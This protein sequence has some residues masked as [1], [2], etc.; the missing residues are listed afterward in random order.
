MS[1]AIPPSTLQKFTT[2]GDLLR[3][4][5]R[6]AGITQVELSLAVGY[7]NA[8]ISR[9]EQN[10]RPPDPTTI[11]A[12]FVPALGLENEPHATS[13]LLELA[14]TVRRE[15]S[16]SAG[17]CPYKGLTYFDEG[18]ADLFVG[19]EAVTSKLVGRVLRLTSRQE[20]GR[21]RFLT[22]VGASGS[23][24][25]SLVRAGLLPALRWNPAS[26]DWLIYVLTPTAHPIESLALAL[27]TEDG[28]VGAPARFADDLMSNARCLHL[29]CSRAAK[30][31]AAAHVLLLVDQFEELFSLCTLETERQAFVGNLL[32]AACDP[33]GA[34]IVLTTLRADFYTHCA[35]YAGLREALAQQQEYIGALN[36]VELRR[37]IEE[38]AR[39][40]RWDFEP[41]LVDLLV[42]DVGH[43]PGALPLLSH[44]LL[45]TWER[46]RGRTMTL[47]GYAASGG[48]RGAIAETAQAVFEDRFS[49]EQQAIARRIFLH[50]TE[51]GDE[52]GTGDT[53]R[54]ASLEEL[55][56]EPGEAHATRIVLDALVDAR[57]ITVTGDAVE[58][59]HEALIREWPALRGWLEDDREGLRLHRH[60]TQA[61]REWAA[62]DR[63]NEALYRGARLIQAREWAAANAAEIYP[64]EREFLDAS[65]READREAAE[66]EL[67]RQ[68]ELA[69][70]QKLAKAESAR[71]EEQ[72]RASNRLRSRNRI[73]SGIGVL[74]LLLAALAGIFGWQSMQNMRRADANLARAKGLGLA[75]ASEV[76]LVHGGDAD[77]AA[78]LSIRSLQESY[79]QEAEST[80]LTA[81]D[82]TYFRRAYTG[83]TGW[84]YSIAVSPD[85]RYILTGSNDGTARLWGLL[86]GKEVRRF[87]DPAAGIAA[88]AFSP[89][90]R[91]VA[92]GDNAG[93]LQ[94]W[95]ANTGA[96]LRTLKGHGDG[97]TSVA[98]SPDGRALLSASGDKT[99]RLWDA[100]T[101]V[102]TR[103]FMGHTAAVTD[104]VFAPSGQQILTG[105]IDGTARIWETSTGA[106]ARTFVADTNGSNTDVTAVA[107]S[108]DGQLLLIAHRYQGVSVQNSQSGEQICAMAGG[109]RSIDAAV[110]SPD[111]RYV[112]T[113]GVDGVAALWSARQCQK[114]RQSIDTAF[115]MSGI[116]AVAF[117]PDGRYFVTGGFDDIARLWVT[118]E[119]GALRTFSPR[120]EAPGNATPAATEITSIAVSPDSKY[121]MAGSLDQ[122]ARLWDLTTGAQVR[123]FVG[124]TGT[125]NAVAFSADGR[126]ALSGSG[127]HTVRVWD[128]TSGRQLRRIDTGIRDVTGVA[129]SPDGKKIFATGTGDLAADD[130]PFAM[131]TR[132]WDASSGLLVHAFDFGFSAAL[133]AGAK[134][135]IAVSADG[136]RV[137]VRN[138][139]TGALLFDISSGDGVCDFPGTNGEVLA[140]ALSNDG[141]YALTGSSDRTARLWDIRTCGQVRA[142]TENTAQ[143]LSVAFS[144]DGKYI[145]AGLDDNTARLWELNTGTEIRAFSAHTGPVDAVAFTPDGRS[146]LTGS[147]DGTVR[148]WDTDYHDTIRFACSMMRRDLSAEE[149]LQYG[150][151]DSK[152][153][154]P[155]R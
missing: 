95:D 63:E 130:P 42:H 145:V 121:L 66:R 152:P 112:L 124:H 5:R 127:D 47:G 137:L 142:F 87:T 116:K 143:I 26:A 101:G 53:R 84:I 118:P 8:Q 151:A 106:V 54:R 61:A 3:F 126:F 14:S 40:G 136:K 144:P 92:T 117:S 72:A 133:P 76:L 98:F 97:I 30:A 149:R 17:L 119:S 33:G 109:P 107:F 36:D 16:P 74:A 89:D 110:F 64:L 154:C 59:A 22:I 50:L 48:V 49:P 38:P 37:A 2:F 6:R 83:H 131:S 20:Y 32:E 138:M 125:V 140:V 105:S 134:P 103:V 1:S 10:L 104:A 78:L 68:N 27:S 96:Q 86:D 19:R 148:L 77:T 60:L 85:G 153:T 7:S 13:R 35:A 52:S 4:L 69:A 39:R 113:G 15:D 28:P 111:S 67:Q 55:I 108:P 147:H 43:E 80:L 90:G 93:T 99:V 18:D 56:V 75:I 88:A 141:R 31:A 102:L 70:A 79:S 41:G 29:F 71:A 24:K 100:G 122:L 57:L 62:M 94:I 115:G 44:A 114:V 139:A 11:E 34:A 150:I 65:G 129:F 146:V 135:M 132:V 51:L 128:V 91:Y 9:L 120:I 45:E 21:S 25:S 123:S 12:R 46:R 82:R 73:I 155:E 23:G 81:L 58:V